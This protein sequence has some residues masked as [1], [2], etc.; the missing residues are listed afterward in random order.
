MKKWW[1]AFLAMGLFLVF[2][3]PVFALELKLGGSYFVQGFYEDNMLLMKEGEEIPSSI[4]N[5]VSSA[6]WYAQRLRLEPVLKVSDFLTLNMRID[7]MERVWGQTPVGSEYVDSSW[8]NQRNLTSEQNIL[9]RRVWVD[10]LTPIGLFLVG[11]MNDGAWGTDFGDLPTEGPEIV[12]IIKIGPVVAGAAYEK[13]GE[14]RLGTFRTVPYVN[15]TNPADSGV[16]RLVLEPGYV[17]SDI[18]KYC[19]TATYFWTSGMAGLLWCNV[20]V[21][22]GRPPQEMSFPKYYVA[23]SEL[24]YN[25]YEAYIKATFFDKLY[26][27]GEYQYLV[28]KLSDWDKHVDLSDIDYEAMQWYLLLRYTVGPVYFGVQYAHSDGDDPDTEDTSEAVLTPGYGN[29]QPC[30]ILFNDWLDRWRGPLGG[31]ARISS[32]FVNADL[33]QVF[34]G[35][36]PM[37]KLSFK[38]SYTI[39]NA[40]EKPAGFVGDEYGSE[41]DLTATYK[42]YDNLEYMVGFAYLW[43]GDYFKGYSAGNRIDD[44]YLVMHQLTL[45][46]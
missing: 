30:H 23:E 6:A 7:A 31:H 46:F 21:A 41:F 1:I 26:V 40:D 19:L 9:F 33:Y 34:A 37:L 38:A 27:E 22:Q 17:D 44:S 2:S 28:G 16:D 12:Y 32:L 15:V 18:D 25:S 42:I 35:Y 11:Y 5:K 45:S 20:R 8:L 24:Y 36:S 29:W 4:H 3:V 13:A 43:T 14:G 39:A 10:F